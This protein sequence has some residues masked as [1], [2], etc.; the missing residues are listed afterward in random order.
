[1]TWKETLN[2]A[3]TRTTGYQ[4][5]RAGTPAA[6]PAAKRPR[7]GDV[8]AGD[9]LVEAPVFVICTLRSGSTLLRVLLDSH[10]QIRSPH[11]LHLRYVS[12]HFD[13]KWSE[14]S[15]AE[16]GLDTKAAE[17][18][19][20][21]R[22]LQ[23][24]LAASG[25]PIIA[26]KTPNNVFI[27][28]RLRECW[29]D[30]RFIFLLRHPAA[31]ARSRQNVRGEH[32]DDDEKNA[33]LIRRYCEALEQARQTYDGH[34][35]RYEELTADP[36]TVTQGICAFLGIAVGGGDARVR[37]VRPRPLQGRPRRLGRQ[38]QDRPDPAARA[39]AAARGDPARAARD[40]REVGLSTSRRATSSTLIMRISCAA[41]TELYGPP[42][43][44]CA[45][46]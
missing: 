40:V 29:P 15:M 12:V 8:R 44:A 30:A 17:Y 36:A 42:R 43:S 25:K 9:R 1:M 11:E 38:D 37:P 3:L 6:K 26:D 33:E 4:L 23:R 32:A 41:C 34:T 2:G 20:W 16:L 21:D 31:I 39:A 18:L 7:V 5:Q 10:S 28:D 13:Q 46:V 24:E 14:R 22:L 35:V 19:L 27:V 45:N